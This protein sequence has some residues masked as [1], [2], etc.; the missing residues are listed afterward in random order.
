[1]SKETTKPL[2]QCKSFCCLGKTNP[3]IISKLK[4]YCPD[5][6]A[7]DC[8]WMDDNLNAGEKSSLET[9]LKQYA[10]DKVPLELV[11]CDACAQTYIADPGSCSECAR[12]NKCTCGSE[13]E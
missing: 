9:V 8:Q 1:M 11:T 5:A 13:K 2:T 12:Q 4:N 10:K 3:E 7:I 6:T